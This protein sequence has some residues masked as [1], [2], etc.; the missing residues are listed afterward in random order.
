MAY[1]SEQAKTVDRIYNERQL[2]REVAHTLEAWARESERGGWSTHQ[3]QPQR[4]LAARIYA[5]LGRQS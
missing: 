4:E 5:F 2:L 1:F 3:V